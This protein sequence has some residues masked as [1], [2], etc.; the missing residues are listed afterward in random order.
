MKPKLLSSVGSQH[1]RRVRV[2]IH[3]LDIDID[4]EEVM[5]GAQGFGGD[6]RQGFLKLNPNGK[7]PVLQHH[8]VVLWESNTIMGY[9]ADLHGETE[10]WP[11]DPLERAQVSMW[12]VWQAAHLTPAADGLFYENRVK[13]MFLQQE[14]D[15]AEVARLEGSFRR[16]MGVLE[17]R[18]ESSETL[19]L[20]RFTCADISV[21]S[22]LMHA[23]SSRMPLAEHP[24]VDAWLQR[25]Q[26]RPSWLATEPPA[27]PG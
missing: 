27:M 18:L 10:L 20:G 2:L 16:W 25:V 22:A 15:T 11:R 17:S 24:V 21:A 19:A 6:D 3:E 4:I 8:G 14:T 12:Q 5:F 9:L 7:V 23:E 26:Q 13:P 1:A